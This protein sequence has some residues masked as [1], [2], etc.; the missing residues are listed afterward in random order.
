MGSEFGNADI[1]VFYSFSLASQVLKRTYDWD[2]VAEVPGLAE[3]FAAIGERDSTKP[4]VADHKEAM[5]ALMT[6]LEAAK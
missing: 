5:A 2:I 3:C 4:V 6:Q 1:F